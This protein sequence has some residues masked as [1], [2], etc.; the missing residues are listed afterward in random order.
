MFVESD[1]PRETCHFTDLGG[2]EP[3]AVHN[4]GRYDGAAHNVPKRRHKLQGG[5]GLV[6]IQITAV[7][8]VAIRQ[9]R[10]WTSIGSQVS[11]GML[12]C[13]VSRIRKHFSTNHVCQSFQRSGA[14]RR[15]LVRNR[16]SLVQL[17]LEFRPSHY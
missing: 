8:T 14:V 12:L 15:F 1:G 17:G 9:A 7:V 5:G 11:Y 3:G 10:L 2:L 16:D 4:G 13:R 6:T